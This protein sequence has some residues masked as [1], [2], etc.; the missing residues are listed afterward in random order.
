MCAA[1][2]QAANNYHSDMQK[3]LRQRACSNA[4]ARTLA[5]LLNQC[6]NTSSQTR[7]IL[8]WQT[9]LLLYSLTC[10]DSL[11]IFFPVQLTC[12]VISQN[13]CVQALAYMSITVEMAGL[14]FRTLQKM[15]M[16]V[17][18]CK[19]AEEATLQCLI[20]SQKVL[21]WEVTLGTSS[22]AKMLVMDDGKSSAKCLDISPL[23]QK[24][25]VVPLLSL[26]DTD[27]TKRCLTS[28]EQLQDT[29]EHLNIS[30]RHFRPLSAGACT[31]FSTH[32]AALGARHA[33]ACAAAS[34]YAHM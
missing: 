16:V 10:F 29:A 24:A 9:S 23:S 25:I 8:T 17:K 5:V 22:F 12:I 34:L 1:K 11:N 30:C 33:I 3:S 13:K 26:I 28:Q 6:H 14:L 19:T 32:Q 7:K 2:W 4:D 31:V 15:C 27:V 18:A 21:C 20:L